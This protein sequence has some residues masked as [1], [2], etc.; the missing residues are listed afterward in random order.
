MVK[1]VDKIDTK[2]DIYIYIFSSQILLWKL[3]HGQWG[4][5]Y[6]ILLKASPDY[7]VESN[8]VGPL[9]FGH[10]GRILLSTGRKIGLYDTVGQTIR[11]LYSLDQESVV[12]GKANLNSIDGP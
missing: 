7:S 12:T 4:R 6:G 1:S 5:A 9:A 10:G 11:S 2:N 3:E 8:V